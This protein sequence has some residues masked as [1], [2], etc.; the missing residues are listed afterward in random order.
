MNPIKPFAMSFALAL[1]LTSC[2]NAASEIDTVRNEVKKKLPQRE[3][4]SVRTTPVKGLFEVVLAPRQVVYV[5]GKANYL[6]VGDL[7]DLNKKESLTE[8]RMKELMRT[9]FSKLP[10]EHAFKLVRGDGSRKVAVFSDPDCP[11]CKKLEM[12]V[13]NRLD[14]V[15]VYTFLLP[16]TSLHPDAPRKASLVWCSA[17]RQ[18]TWWS[19][20]LEGKPLEGEAKCETPLDQ[21]AALARQ[22][23]IN[24]TPA[25]VFENGDIV[26]GA[27]SK[28]AFEAKLNEKPTAAAQPAAKPAAP[29][30]A[31]PAS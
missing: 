5:D 16:L 11:F 7:V 12:E 9:D 3:I 18:K 22:L 26:P 2:A 14:N 23:D 30:A 27:I 15:T 13:I 20:M 28:E 10:F 21:I 25:I 31:K 17:D 6:I 1:S 24:G 4:Q 19:W 8:A 29:A